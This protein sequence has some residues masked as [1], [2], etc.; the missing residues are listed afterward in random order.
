MKPGP[1]PPLE[2]PA[3]GSSAR[4]R[5][6]GGRRRAGRR[7]KGVRGKR[8]RRGG[9]ASQ[10]RAQ[11]LRKAPG[12]DPLL[13]SELGPKAWGGRAP[14][15]RGL[16]PAK[17][18]RLHPGA[19]TKASEGARVLPCFLGARVRRPG[20]ARLPSAGPPAGC[21]ATLFH[22]AAS[23]CPNAPQNASS[24][25]PQRGLP[26]PRCLLPRFPAASARPPRPLPPL[27]TRRGRCAGGKRKT[28]QLAGAP[29]DP[30]NSETRS[31]GSRAG[32]RPRAM[33]RLPCQTLAGHGG[34]RAT[35][36]REQDQECTC[37]VNVPSDLHP[38]SS[39]H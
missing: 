28:R 19:G 25:P 30:P 2:G 4:N 3:R 39:T 22:S 35:L 27:Q 10:V 14:S 26:S 13:R 6:Q 32:T 31:R 20:L 21:V 24:P 23:P 38:P 18:R 16:H 36:P 33:A 11:A 12:P 17:G 34:G 1:R 8:E 37:Q 5:T 7:T 15:L 9:A 29:G